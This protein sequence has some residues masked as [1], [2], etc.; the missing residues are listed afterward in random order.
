MAISGLLTK[1]F[2]FLVLMVIGYVFARKGSVGEEFTKGLSYLVI[3]LFM[4]A[5]IINPVLNAELSLSGRELVNTML[6]LSL[7][8]L[9]S[10]ALASVA[11]RLAPVPKDKKAQFLL[12]IAVMNNMFIALPVVEEIYGAQAVFYCSL[13]CI[14]FN[15][16]LYSYGVWKLKSGGE[17]SVRIKDILSI[18]LIATLTALLLFVTKLPVPELLRQLCSS[19]AGATMPLSMLVIGVSL[20]SVSL[21][22]AFRHKLMYLASFLRLAIAPA[23]TWL[24]CRS[25]TDDPMLLSCAVIIA[26]CPTGVVTSVLSIQYGKDPVFTSEGILQSTALSLLTI[27]VVAWLVV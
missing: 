24:I 22:D 4:S 26:A 27:P 19:I 23:L 6:V 12:L 7:T 15:I 14:P 10:Y 17:G 9:I 1:M 13:S 16:L 3:N 18:P 5:S 20:G 25:L 2:I 8:M 21:L 11:A